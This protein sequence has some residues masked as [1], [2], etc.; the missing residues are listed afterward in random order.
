MTND[1]R[2]TL[3]SRYGTSFIYVVPR[4]SFS[5]W[6]YRKTGRREL[7]KVLGKRGGLWSVF[8]Q[9]TAAEREKAGENA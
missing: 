7:R 4:N 8:A 6:G 2:K 5:A 9:H 1:E 3:A